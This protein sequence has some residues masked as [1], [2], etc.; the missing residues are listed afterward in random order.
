[1]RQVLTLVIAFILISSCKTIKHVGF[2]G[3]WKLDHRDNI[4][5]NFS[6][7]EIHVYSDSIKL[8]DGNNY[9]QIGR[10][11]PVSDSL[12]ITFS[13]GS[14]SKVC[15]KSVSDSVMELAGKKYFRIEKDDFTTVFDY[16]LFGVITK[17]N[18]HND[19]NSP[20]LH[21]V[22]VN[23]TPGVILNDVVTSPENI[24]KFLIGEHGRPTSVLLYVGKGITFK[25]LI[26]TYNWILIAGLNQVTL[27][28]ASR[29]F[30][31][32]YVQNDKIAI[33]DALT[34]EF[35]LKNRIPPPPIRKSDTAIL[36]NVV[37]FKD[38]RE[39]AALE[40]LNDSTFYL[41]QVDT[42]LELKDYL[43]LK[44]LIDDN[45]KIEIEIIGL[46]P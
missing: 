9:C 28:L 3:Y 37:L 39:L 43:K 46:L 23:D 18:L 41:I 32:F 7:F 12:L 38:S 36:R 45:P 20:V 5:N 42:R 15:V 35:R 8:V 13:N 19:V 21:L 29:G 1:M 4:E 10:F 44:S 34:E 24:P 33:S 40:S 14:T 26:E 22:K 30:E 16:E 11:T 31:E 25:E 6:P 2:V 27:V 17:T